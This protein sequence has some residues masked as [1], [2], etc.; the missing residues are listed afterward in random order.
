MLGDRGRRSGAGRQ[1]AG[2]QG[3]APGPPP[4]HLRRPPR[5][6][7][8]QARL[9]PLLSIRASAW[10][11]VRGQEPRLLRGR[12]REG[13]AGGR[14]HHLLHLRHHRQ[15]EGRHADALERD[16]ARRV[17]P[18]GR[19]RPPRGR[20]ARVSADGVGRRCRLYP[21]PQPRR[22]LLCQLS[23]EPGDGAARSARARADDRA[24]AAA[25]LGEHADGGAG[26]G[27]RRARLQAV[28]LRALPVRRRAGRDPS[29]RRQAGSRLAPPGVHDRQRARLHADPGSAGPAPRQ[30]GPDGRRPARSGHVPFLPLD[31]RQPQAGLRLDGDDRAGVAPAERRGQSD[32]GRPAVPGHRGQDR[33]PRRG[34]RPRSRHLQGLPQERRGH[35]RGHR[36]RGVVPHGRRGLRRPARPPGDHRSGEGRGGPAGRHAVRAA[37]HREQAE[38]Q[39]VHSRG[40]GLRQRPR[41]RHRD[42]RDRSEHGRE[43]GRAPRDS[44]HELRRPEPEAGG[45]RGD[46]GRDPKGQRDP[47]GVDADPPLPAPDQ[48]SGG[49]R[50]RDDAHAQGATTLRGRE[51][52]PGH[53]RVLLRRPRGRARSCHHLRRR[54]SGRH[55]VA[56][57]G[58]ERRRAGGGPCLTTSAS[59]S[60]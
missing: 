37:V 42:D 28:D 57:A 11:R 29:R 20:R 51:V 21:V 56:R 13:Q 9:A 55:A 26:E 18:Q 22:R 52:R 48:G 58:R 4:R 54:A 53:R 23:R 6:A 1:G 49:R 14:R 46:P 19:R 39:P 34:A 38:V 32:D 35:A 31:R 47:A 15:S 50:R 30:V 33:R 24:G 60:S 10:A 2:A 36:R 16:R 17:L 44:I 5:H 8:L 27:R 25:H 12:D 40:G 7:A 45:V 3:S 59:S 41:L 43:L